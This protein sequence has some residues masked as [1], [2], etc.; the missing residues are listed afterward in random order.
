MGNRLGFSRTQANARKKCCLFTTAAFLQIVSEAGW[1]AAIHLLR[2]FPSGLTSSVLT[3]NT[4][5]DILWGSYHDE[6]KSPVN[7]SETPS[8]GVPSIK[9]LYWKPQTGNPKNIV[10][11]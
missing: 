9:G 3:G 5:P 7:T 4:R 8:S 1:L 6:A 10:G 11:I 2:S